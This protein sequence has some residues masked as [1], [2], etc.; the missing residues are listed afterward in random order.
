MKELAEKM[1]ETIDILQEVQKQVAMMEASVGDITD[2]G[3]DQAGFNNQIQSAI[4]DQSALLE[5]LAGG[6]QAMTNW[7]LAIN[8]ALDKAGIEVDV[9][10][11]KKQRERLN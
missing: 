11:T 8:A 2:F 3:K 5:D 10:G 9:E 6:Y 7:F 4:N 1:T